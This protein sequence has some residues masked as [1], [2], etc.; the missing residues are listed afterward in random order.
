MNWGAQNTDYFAS[1]YYDGM[2][3]ASPDRWQKFSGDKNCAAL[4]RRQP[5]LDRV[6]IVISGGAAS[7]P[8]FPGY[9]GE[10]LAD[11]AVG[12][13]PY[14]APNAYLLYEVGKHL[15]R[16]KG[17]LLLYNNFAGDFLNNDMAEE[18]LAME[19]IAAASF[20]ATDDIASAMGEARGK[21]SGR[22]GVALLIKI[23]AKC[24]Q[25]GM[26]LAQIQAVLQKANARLGT[27][28]MMADFDKNEI[29]YGNGF[30]GEPGF[31]TET[32]MDMGQTARKAMDLLVEDLKPQ[33]AERLVLL[34]N[35]LR[36]TSYSDGYYMGK[37]AYEYLANSFDVQQLRVAN[38]SNITDVY[39]F[40]FTLLCVDEALAPYVEGTVHADSFML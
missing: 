22:C 7:G 35:R 34:V 31:C 30:S 29:V 15:G 38:F 17:V 8:L 39:G 25:L 12:G 1:N 4:L 40:N 13:G 5:V 9:V 3:H 27:L 10:G 23:A 6:N 37:L 24:A 36:Y 28:S 18:L 16:Q 26:G 14:A 32:H 33:K 20:A 2:V 19:G 11:A 21:R